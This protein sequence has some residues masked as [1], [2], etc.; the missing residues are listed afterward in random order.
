MHCATTNPASFMCTIFFAKAQHS[1]CSG[2][3]RSQNRCTW[4]VTGM[5]NLGPSREHQLMEVILFQ[6]AIASTV[7][8]M[9]C[10]SLTSPIQAS[11]SKKM[12]NT[13][14]LYGKSAAFYTTCASLSFCLQ[15]LINTMQFRI[16]VQL[17]QCAVLVLFAMGF[18]G[19]CLNWKFK[20]RN[21]KPPLGFIPPTSDVFQQWSASMYFEQRVRHFI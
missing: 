17:L 8:N 18:A 2:F 7:P 11:P 13:L 4:H 5:L 10:I 12:G 20:M 14:A 1:L 6:R 3:I 15:R 19:K 21:L 16:K 9:L